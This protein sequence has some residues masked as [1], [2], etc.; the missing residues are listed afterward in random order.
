MENLK[1][2][3][4]DNTDLAE[5]EA[6]NKGYRNDIYVKISNK[7]YN[8]RA[9]DLVRLQQDFKSE[10]E[11]YGYYSIEPNLVL[12]KEVSRECIYL[13][14]EK[15]YEQKFFEDL[16]PIDDYRVIDFFD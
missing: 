3:F 16:K 7:V 9:Y 2:I 15:L 8:L 11:E 13:T 14:I 4:I 5:F 10:L 12:V 6:S 1:I